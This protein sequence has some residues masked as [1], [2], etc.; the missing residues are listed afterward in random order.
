MGPSSTSSAALS[1]DS[2]RL[3]H[4]SSSAASAADASDGVTADGAAAAAAFAVRSS[5]ATVRMRCSRADLTVAVLAG[6]CSDSCESC[7]AGC[8]QC[9]GSECFVATTNSRRISGLRNKAVCKQRGW[10]HHLPGMVPA[11]HK[12]A[13]KRTDAHLGSGRCQDQLPPGGLPLAHTPQQQQR[14]QCRYG[15][16]RCGDQQPHPPRC[17]APAGSWI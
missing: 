2:C 11:C 5:K 15:E 6:L 7:R 13:F 3:R 12:P 14:H 10:R 9:Q 16:R 4:A 8:A 17:A 1:H